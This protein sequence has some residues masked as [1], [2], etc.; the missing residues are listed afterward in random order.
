MCNVLQGDFFE[1]VIVQS[2]QKFIKFLFFKEVGKFLCCAYRYSN[3]P[4][5]FDLVLLRALGQLIPSLTL[6]IIW[7]EV[8]GHG[9][10]D[11]IVIDIIKAK[12]LAVKL[13]HSVVRDQ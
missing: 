11:V 1:D 2:E 12:V 3:I 9:C 8:I 5:Y 13:N 6:D 7:C 4:R 10:L